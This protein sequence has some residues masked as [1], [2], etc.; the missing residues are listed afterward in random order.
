MKSLAKSPPLRQVVALI[1]YALAI[2]AGLKY[3][4]DF[5]VQISGTILGVV[6]AINSAVFCSIVVGMFVEQA[7]RALDKRGAGPDATGR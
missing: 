2:G 7:Q 1:A 3:G 5:G 6:L 4:Y